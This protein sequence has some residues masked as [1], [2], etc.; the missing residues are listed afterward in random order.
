MSD[1]WW[2]KENTQPIKIGELLL[3]MLSM[4]MIGVVIGFLIW[5]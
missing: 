4:L 1:H 3:A 2:D 5:Y